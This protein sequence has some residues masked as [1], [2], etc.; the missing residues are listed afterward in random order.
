MKK[1]AESCDIYICDKSNEPKSI[2]YPEEEGAG[3]KSYEQLENDITLTTRRT[4]HD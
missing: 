3:F 1:V 4:A 2:R